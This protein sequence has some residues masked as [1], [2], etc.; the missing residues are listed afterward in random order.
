MLKRI[1]DLF[2]NARLA[3]IAERLTVLPVETDLGRD[4]D[5][6]APPTL[7]QRLAHD[8]LRAAETIDRRRIDQRDAAIDS[9]MNGADGLRFIGSAP[10]PSADRPCAER[11]ARNFERGGEIFNL[12]V[13]RLDL[14]GHDFVFFFGVAA[15]QDAMRAASQNRWA[16]REF[17]CPW[18]R[19]RRCRAPARLAEHP[20]HRRRLAVHGCRRS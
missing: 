18:Q 5:A 13:V 16:E 20:A 9:L 12:G 3:G 10:H 11:D 7:G 6:L 19:R 15:S 4:Q 17:A 1:L 14:R 8:L 2:A